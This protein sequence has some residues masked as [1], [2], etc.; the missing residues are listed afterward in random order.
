MPITC[1]GSRGILLAPLAIPLSAGSSPRSK[2]LLGPPAGGGGDDGGGGGCRS[3]AR[4]PAASGRGDAEAGASE[5]S[6]PPA[7][8]WRPGAPLASLARSRLS[9]LR[10]RGI[11]SPRPP[12]PPPPGLGHAT[13]PRLRP[14]RPP[15][16]PLRLRPPTSPGGNRASGDG[17]G[18][19]R[20]GARA[21][22]R[23]RTPGGVWRARRAR[24][25][26]RPGADRAERSERRCAGLAPR[27]ARVPRGSGGG[28][29][30]TTARLGRGGAM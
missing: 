10:S 18:Q 8:G 17:A 27:A 25:L 13:F 7:A 4:P 3:Q 11:V 5:S 24:P 9:P 20:R 6:S 29:D 2:L 19:Q 1:E 22:R 30:L 12:A 21:R 28:S 26:G 14:P 15:P 23:P 16:P